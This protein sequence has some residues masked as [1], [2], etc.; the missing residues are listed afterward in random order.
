M[1]AA[2]CCGTHPPPSPDIT[3]AQTLAERRATASLREVA[4]AAFARQ[5]RAEEL[6]RR[7]ADEARQREEER[8]R[9]LTLGEVRVAAARIF[10]INAD[11]A[12]CVGTHNSC[13]VIE[14]DGIYLYCSSGERSPYLGALR[15]C[16]ECGDWLKEDHAV[17]RPQELAQ[18]LPT[19]DEPM[20]CSSCANREEAVWRTEFERA[21]AVEWGEAQA[22]HQSDFR[23]RVIAVLMD[24]GVL[25]PEAAP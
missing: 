19:L 22:A 15:R 11:G 10:G 12:P 14:V 8:I 16:A 20:R 25:V 24:L 5:Q 13:A 18:L 9:L 6:A 2:A 7:E 4:L 3:E 1:D 23:E 17:T 21:E